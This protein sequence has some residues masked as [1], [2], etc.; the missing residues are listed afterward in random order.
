MLPHTPIYK[1]V[2]TK[3]KILSDNSK[4]NNNSRTRQAREPRIQPKEPIAANQ[5]NSPTTRIT[6]HTQHC[7]NHIFTLHNC[8]NSGSQ[9]AALKIN[10]F[11]IHLHIYSNTPRIFQCIYT[12]PLPPYPPYHIFN[13]NSQPQAPAPPTPGRSS[14]RRP[15][16]PAGQAYRGHAGGAGVVPGRGYTRHHHQTT[17]GRGEGVMAWGVVSQV[18]G[19]VG[20][21]GVMCMVGE[22]VSDGMAG[23]T[24]S[25]YW[26]EERVM[27]M[28][29]GRKS[30]SDGEKVMVMKVRVKWE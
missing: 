29:E 14:P 10:Y 17:Y 28:G 12:P 16:F 6:F 26:R 8:N 5:Q 1:S 21:E 30:G 4:G 20:C 19:W 24:V 22:G 25:Q 23:V 7:F 2:Q 3:Q 9:F 13:T 18:Y 15:Q 27:V 11:N